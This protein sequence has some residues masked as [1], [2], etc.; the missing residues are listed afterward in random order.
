MQVCKEDEGISICSALYA[1]GHRSLLLIQHTGPLDSVNAPSA[2]AVKGENPVCIELFL[3]FLSDILSEILLLDI[4]KL[5][6]YNNV[7][8]T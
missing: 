3:S 4:Q 7:A 5:F 2:G 6:F 8:I 1:T